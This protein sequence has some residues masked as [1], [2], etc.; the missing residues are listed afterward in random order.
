MFGPTDA[1]CFDDTAVKDE[2]LEGTSLSESGGSQ[3]DGKGTAGAR[4][5]SSIKPGALAS[6]LKK[7]PVVPAG[8]VSVLRRCLGRLCRSLCY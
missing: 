2:T 7:A 3:G 1:Q 6:I 5:R 4:A 8:A